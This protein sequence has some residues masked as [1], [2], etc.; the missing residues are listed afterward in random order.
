MTAT[1]RDISIGIERELSFTP[2]TAE[3]RLLDSMHA[4]LSVDEIV[5]LIAHELVASG[6]TGTAVALACC[7]KNFEDPVL[8]ALW[9]EQDRLFPLLDS[10]PADVWNEGGC[11]VSASTM[12]V[13]PFP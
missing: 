13:F 5:R 7:C 10:F 9:V 2:R 4:C 12:S 11:T 8:D 6:G 1:V 3:A